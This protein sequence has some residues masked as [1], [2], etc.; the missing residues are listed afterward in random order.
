MIWHIGGIIILLLIIEHLIPLKTADF[1]LIFLTHYLRVLS[2]AYFY[3]CFGK[4]RTLF[5]KWQ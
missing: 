5:T 3:E 4:S 1:T 2:R